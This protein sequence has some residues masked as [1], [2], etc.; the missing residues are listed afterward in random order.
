MPADWRLGKRTISVRRDASTFTSF[1]FTQLT[2][3]ETQ[4]PVVVVGKL[5]NGRIL[6]V[7][8]VVSHT[9]RS[10]QV[11]FNYS[12]KL[13]REERGRSC[14]TRLL[15]SFY[16]GNFGTSAASLPFEKAEI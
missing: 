4:H 11:C 6:F 15:D 5:C 14:P 10:S 1:L 2:C 16:E 8:I 12:Q 9:V 13:F 7:V 3:A